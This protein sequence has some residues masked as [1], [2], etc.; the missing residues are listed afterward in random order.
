[1]GNLV[2]HNLGSITNP[3]PYQPQLS[4]LGNGNSACSALKTAWKWKE[5]VVLRIRHEETLLYSLS[6]AMRL[7][8]MKSSTVVSGKEVLLSLCGFALGS[9]G[10]M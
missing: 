3:V 5:T 7:G 1:M 9:G 4:C 2:T 8:A 6:R 10:V